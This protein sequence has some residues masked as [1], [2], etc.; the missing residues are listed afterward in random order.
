MDAEDLPNHR[1]RLLGVH[2]GSEL[3]PFL[4]GELWV[5][6]HEYSFE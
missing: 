2:E 3:I 1:L 4:L 5:R 6:S